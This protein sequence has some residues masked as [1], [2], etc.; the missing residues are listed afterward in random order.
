MK[1][2]TVTLS[3]FLVS[4][5]MCFGPD[6]SGQAPADLPQ[7]RDAA[8]KLMRDGNFKEALDAYRA[9]LVRPR[10]DAPHLV[11]EDL[12]QGVQCLRR[13]GQD[14]EF[15][16]FVEAAVKAQG[17]NWRLLQAAAEQYRGANHYG[18]VVGGEFERGHHRGGGEWA[19]VEA[20]D[21]VRALQLM[22]EAEK[23]VRR[24]SDRSAVGYFYLTYA[25]FYQH[26]GS[27]SWRM[28]TLTDIEALPDVEKGH[29]D[30]GGARNGAPVDADGNPVFHA[31][32][33]S[34]EKAATDGERWRWLLAR[35]E[36]AGPEW[37]DRAR[38][39]F[40]QFLHGQFGVQT[41]ARY[42]WFFQPRDEEGGPR[43]YDLHTLTGDE[44][45]CQLATG[46]RRLRLPD[47][48]SYVRLFRELAKS[49][50]RQIRQG[51]LLNLASIHEN[52]RQYDMAVSYWEDLREAGRQREAPRGG[53]HPPDPRQLGAVRERPVPARRQARHRR[54]PLPQ[55][56]GRRVHRL[57][58][59]CGE[60]A[61]GRQRP[62]EVP[63]R[64]PRLAADRPPPARA[65]PGVRE[66]DQVPGRAGR[67][68]DARPRAAPQP[69][70]PAHHRRHAPARGRCLPPGREDAGRQHQPHPAPARRSRRGPQATGR[71]DPLLRGRR[72]YG[73]SRPGRPGLLRPPRR[74]DPQQQETQDR[75]QG[76]RRE[77]R[78]R[79]AVRAGR[80]RR[81][82][83]L[84]VAGD[85]QGREPSRLA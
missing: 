54:F 74:V 46:I 62:C 32:P 57:A 9:L 69:L 7:A 37:A 6:C 23:L 42:G 73:R 44:T 63:P 12:G 1:R 25:A 65:P 82:A 16:A 19:N 52:R 85:G 20:R 21:R 78:R 64:P 70:R 47:E 28:Q 4:A 35:A 75:H 76:I 10:P 31:V 77:D 36:Q 40:A 56:Q 84:P 30:N 71:Q 60:G 17:D 26:D 72:R 49:E 48:F 83:G 67:A 5:C 18:V 55:R 68:V 43:T 59:R 51:A 45:I 2:T 22:G 53:A 39:A 33:A 14:K 38:L 80:Q 29:Y 66:P 41:M 34:M 13:L 24:E 11:C 15:D 61:R 81:A 50:L 3:A 58:S 8:R 27:N 79:W